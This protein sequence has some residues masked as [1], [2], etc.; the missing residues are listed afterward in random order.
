MFVG[1]E[2]KKEAPM[3]QL[4]LA[5]FLCG[6]AELIS[7]QLQFIVQCVSSSQFNF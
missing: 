3:F 1:Y 2:K 5:E 7:A 6:I 4:S